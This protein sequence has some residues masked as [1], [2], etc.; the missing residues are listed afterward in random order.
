MRIDGG[1]RPRALDEPADRA[2]DLGLGAGAEAEPRRGDARRGEAERAA[3]LEHDAVVAGALA[4]A[5][6]VEAGCGL[7]PQRDA[8]GRD[9]EADGVA[10]LV[11]Q[12]AGERVAPRVVDAAH[13]AGVPAELVVLD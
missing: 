1:L 3:G 8:A 12:R 9:L 6:G 2:A 11:A 7:D 5:I 4:P 13:L 10:E